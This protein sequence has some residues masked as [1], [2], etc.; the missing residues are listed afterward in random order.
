VR[1]WSKSV[2]ANGDEQ[3]LYAYQPH[4]LISTVLFWLLC[5]FSCVHCFDLYQA[6]PRGGRGRN[7]RKGVLV[8]ALI[9][10]LICFGGT[11]AIFNAD[12]RISWYECNSG[13]TNGEGGV[14]EDSNG[15]VQ[16]MGLLSDWTTYNDLRF[17]G[18]I[19]G[20]ILLTVSDYLDAT[21]KA[22]MPSRDDGED[23]LNNAGASEA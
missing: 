1:L 17:A 10:Y 19:A 9:A 16:P 6:V 21:N 18:A 8:L 14:W 3:F 4:A 5:G 2:L 22:N 12:I 7:Q 15:L 23:Q 20:I 11:L 13:C